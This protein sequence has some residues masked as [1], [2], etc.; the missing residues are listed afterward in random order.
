MSDVIRMRLC[1]VVLLGLLMVH[2]GC[3]KPADIRPTGDANAAKQAL[4]QTLEAW[5]AGK[6]VEQL[7]EQ[8]PSV[9]FVDDGQRAGKQLTAFTISKEPELGGSHWRVYTELTVAGE[10]PEPVCYAV[11]LGSP[12]SILRSDFLN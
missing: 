9:I 5:K 11:T 12:I 4:T 1:R 10:N 3:G 7:K 8:T 6:T 2:I